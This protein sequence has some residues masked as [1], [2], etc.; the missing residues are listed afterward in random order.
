MII[1][2]KFRSFICVTSHP[3]GCRQNVLEQINYVKEHK[4]VNGPK[5]VLVIGAS[6][7]YGLSSRIMATFGSGADTLGVFYERP[8]KGKNT[9]SAGWYNTVAF[10]KEAKEAGFYAKSINIDAFSSEAKEKV[11]N[12]IKEDLGSVDLIVYSIASPKRI[13]PITGETFNSVIKPIGESFTTKGIN[14]DTG[15]ISDVTV[16]PASEEE[17]RQTVAVMGGED[18]E[19]WINAL[20][21]ADVL[22]KGATTVAYSYIGPEITNP[23]YRSGTVGKAKE[24]LEN[25]A[26]NISNMLKDIDGKVYV[27]VN[28][29]LVT[30]ASLAI[31]AVPLYIAILYK[32]MKEKGIH[33]DCIG[34]I[35]R[36]FEDDLYSDKIDLD[37]LGRIRVD[38]LEMR[39]DVQEE[40]YNIWKKI[41][42]ENI[43]DLSDIEGFKSEFFKLYGFGL[44]EIDYD[45]DVN[46]EEIEDNIIR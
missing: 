33:E 42:N 5:K 22:S 39:E 34:Q 40:V 30:Q 15:N 13:H 41:N 31:P 14:I 29:A 32:V 35:V 26:E 18:W 11:I 2:P 38:D 1:K 19:M 46:I 8:S 17:I 20:K 43:N 27:S 7:G 12:I 9:A 16:E 37:E 25:S 6:T 10:E 24:S 4:V 3:E 21:E 45:K 36:L 28:K 23:I 44:N